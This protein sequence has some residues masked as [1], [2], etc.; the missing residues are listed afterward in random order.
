MDTPRKLA[1]YDAEHPSQAWNEQMAPGEY[2]VHFSHF[3]GAVPVV[4]YC[5]LFSDLDQAIAYA[6]NEVKDRPTL[7]CTIYNHHGLVG[8][9]IRDIRGLEFKGGEVSRR[10]AIWIGLTLFFG[11]AGLAIYD[12]TRNSQLQ[13]PTAIGMPM[14]VPGLTLLV[15]EA[16]S[17]VHKRTRRT[18]AGA[19]GIA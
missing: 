3:N 17:S 8:P 14:V 15:A 1:L 2:A 13:W 6:Q 16:L 12:W 4:P 10:L 18:R 7:R 11:G 19:K 9:P 5:L